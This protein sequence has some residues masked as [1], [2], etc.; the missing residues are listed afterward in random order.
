[1]NTKKITGTEA[2]TSIATAP[3]KALRFI[4]SNIMA[5]VGIFILWK[6]FFTA[7]IGVLSWGLL[8]ENLS[9]NKA[10]VLFV[11]ENSILTG[12]NVYFGF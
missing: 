8:G 9:H 4:C 10:V 1:M 2:I 6:I 5:V 12:L 11:M 7:M 3:I